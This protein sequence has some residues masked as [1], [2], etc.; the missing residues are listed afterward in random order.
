MKRIKARGWKPDLPWIVSAWRPDAGEESGTARLRETRETYS[1]AVERAQ[2]LV[3]AGW[4][5]AEVRE[6]EL[7]GVQ[8]LASSRLR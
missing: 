6:N 4:E 5:S 1:G 2:E 8:V 7:C 3:R